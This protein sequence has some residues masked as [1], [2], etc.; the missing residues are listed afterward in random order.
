MTST[1]TK[2][3]DLIYNIIGYIDILIPTILTVV[4]VFVAWRIFDAWIINAGDES[5][6]E[7]GKSVVLTSVVVFV[8][9]LIL[10]GVIA[11]LRESIFGY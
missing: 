6:V 1:P 4:F 10:W 2:F 5:K 3:K 11:L 8:I 9:I 7:E